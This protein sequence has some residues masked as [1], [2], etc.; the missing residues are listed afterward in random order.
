MALRTADDLF[1]YLVRHPAHAAL[2]VQEPG[3]TLIAHRPDVRQ[4]LASTF[5]VSVLYALARAVATGALDLE[6]SVP[7]AD[8]EGY[9]LAGTDAGA[10]DQ[11]VANF[12]DPTAPT[13]AELANAM[14]AFSDNAATDYLLALLGDAAIDAVPAQLG[15]PLDP[16]IPV[17]G[18]FATWQG[19]A[20]FPRPRDWPRRCVTMTSDD[21][22]REAR[23]RAATLAADR[24]HR[25][26]LVKACTQGPPRA[27]LR[28]LAW[29]LPG[30]TAR[31][32][33]TQMLRAA[34]ADPRDPP[35]TSAVMR[36]FLRW[37]LDASSALRES[38]SDAGYK[39]GT[40]A[41]VL[42]GAWY[43]VRPGRTPRAVVLLL[44]DL[45]LADYDRIL[46]HASHQLFERRLLVDDAFVSAVGQA[47]LPISP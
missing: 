40:L 47:L 32:V 24:T 12:A 36:R 44:A 11:A 16:G 2:V 45:P 26:A 20:H 25:D 5:K 30:G 34:S 19:P 46:A 35:G 27:V 7:Y 9:H 33:A 6:A 29:T 37:P 28:R 15:L 39:P 42:T 17:S 38:F 43:G 3:T 1:A 41:G 22:R 23:S 21:F 8:V 14:I 13:L 4:P 31:A 10:H 18:L